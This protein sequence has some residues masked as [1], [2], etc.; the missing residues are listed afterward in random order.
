MGEGDL[1]AHEGVLMVKHFEGLQGCRI[2]EGCG[3]IHGL[4]GIQ[5]AEDAVLG[6][7]GRGEGI[8]GHGAMRQGAQ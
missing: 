8:R 1:T 2:G 4:G 5:D 3:V 7:E 6:P